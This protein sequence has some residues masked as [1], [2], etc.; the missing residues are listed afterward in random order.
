MGFV[1]FAKG[2][3]EIILITVAVITFNEL[4]VIINF[5]ILKISL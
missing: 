5:V 3:Y 1:I 2:N 4:I